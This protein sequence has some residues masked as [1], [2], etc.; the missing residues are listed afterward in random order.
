MKIACSLLSVFLLSLASAAAFFG[1][2]RRFGSSAGAAAG[3]AA[4]GRPRFFGAESG[5]PQ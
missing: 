5:L 1:R 2:P 4:F 3:S